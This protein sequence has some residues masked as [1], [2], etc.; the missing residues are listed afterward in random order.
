MVLPSCL[1][2]SDHVPLGVLMKGSRGKWN[3]ALPQCFLLMCEP[4]KEGPRPVKGAAPRT[5]SYDYRLQA[6]GEEGI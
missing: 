5:L 3:S 4:Q 2:A 1:S 6:E